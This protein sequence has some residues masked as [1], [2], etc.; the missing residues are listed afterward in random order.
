LLQR[1]SAANRLSE[2]NLGEAVSLLFR[3]EGDPDH[4][5]SEV[6]GVLQRVERLPGDHCIYHIV[7]RS[8]E[9]V[10]V[11]EPDVLKVKIIPPAS[12]P[13]RIPNSW[14]IGGG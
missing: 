10:R 12:G 6:S 1:R 7:R 14:K 3:V 8:G 5:F 13:L 4:P 2:S 11:A 9:M